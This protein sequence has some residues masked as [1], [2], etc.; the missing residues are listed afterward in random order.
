MMLPRPH[1][2]LFFLLPLSLAWPPQELVSLW[3]PRGVEVRGIE[4]RSRRRV[5]RLRDAQLCGGFVS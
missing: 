4:V 5:G 1:Q 2:T 3:K